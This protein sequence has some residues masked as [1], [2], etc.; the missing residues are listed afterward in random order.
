[1]QAWKKKKKRK[2]RMSRKDI[3]KERMKRRKKKEPGSAGSIKCGGNSERIEQKYNSQESRCSSECC[4]GGGREE[5]KVQLCRRLKEEK[6][7]IED[8]KERL[9]IVEG[10]IETLL[11]DR[12]ALLVRLKATEADL[13][14]E[15]KRRIEKE[16][17][18]IRWRKTLEGKLAHETQDR[19]RSARR[20][21]CD[22]EKKKR[23]R[24]ETKVLGG[25]RS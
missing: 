16:E 14:K 15:R 13:E 1:M 3:E 10:M 17:E 18:C 9:Y 12:E 11:E 7:V 23:D 22:R 24:G 19:V 8:V 6:K 25:G 4:A 20:A 2:K 21:E 5:G